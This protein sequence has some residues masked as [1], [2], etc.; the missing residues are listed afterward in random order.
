VEIFV[1]LALAHD[2]QGYIPM[3][4]TNR[5]DHESPADKGRENTPAASVGSIANPFCKSYAILN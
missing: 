1:G 2:L 5:L 4:T 3:V